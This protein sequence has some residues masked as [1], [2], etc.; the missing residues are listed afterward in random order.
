VQVPD[1]NSQIAR[2]E[3]TVRNGA[4]LVLKRAQE[5]VTEAIRCTDIAEHSPVALSVVDSLPETG[6]SGADSD[7]AHLVTSRQWG[8]RLIQNSCIPVRTSFLFF[9]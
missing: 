5:G 2:P 6:E 8:S 7:S 9:R 1:S 4:E 3:A